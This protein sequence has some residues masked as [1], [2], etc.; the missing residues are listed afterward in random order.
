MSD[1]DKSTQKKQDF[2]SLLQAH[3]VDIPKVG[4]VVKGK[5]ISV[6]RGEIRSILKG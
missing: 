2:K 4:D 3:F 1:T 5:V 6:E